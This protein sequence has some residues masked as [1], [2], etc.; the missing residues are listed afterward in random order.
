MILKL[1]YKNQGFIN[2]NNKHQT[3]FCI[4]SDELVCIKW[5]RSDYLK[6]YKIG[7]IE[8]R[9]KL[10]LLNTNLMLFVKNK[11]DIKI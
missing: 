6:Y 9:H 3:V 11:G 5:K 1:N 8:H 7:S 10:K 4:M 2:L